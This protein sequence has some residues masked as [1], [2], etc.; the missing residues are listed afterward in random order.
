MKFP[1]I[2][3]RGKGFENSK[4]SRR[5]FLFFRCEKIKIRIEKNTSKRKS[6]A[7]KIRIDLG[8]VKG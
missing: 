6:T 8:E 2:Q 7:H 4:K 3:L 1:Q 5:G